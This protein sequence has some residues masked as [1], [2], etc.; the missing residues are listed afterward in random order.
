MK[1]I[2][3]LICILIPVSF[4]MTSCS[5]LD[6]LFSQ[7]QTIT[8][9]YDE[10]F[11]IVKVA[12]NVTTILYDGVPAGKELLLVERNAGTTNISRK[13]SREAD[14]SEIPLPSSRGAVHFHPQ[15][16]D[17]K[18]LKSLQ[19]SAESSRAAGISASA[20]TTPV[21][22]VDWQT[23]DEKSLYFL[24][25]Y[26]EKTEQKTFILKNKNNACNVWAEE[27][28][29]DGGEYITEANV[30]ECAE[31]LQKITPLM[32]GVFG[33]TSD[34]IWLLEKSSEN[35][36]ALT[37]YDDTGAKLNVVLIPFGTP[38][39]SNTQVL[40]YFRNADLIYTEL[41]ESNYNYTEENKT[42][43]QTAKTSNK[44]NYLYINAEVLNSEELDYRSTLVHEFQH[45]I[46]FNNKVIKLSDGTDQTT[47]WNE[48]LSL[49]S[50][51]MF[52]K[53]ITEQDT[54]E[55]LL[56]ERLE[57]FMLNYYTLGITQWDN[58]DALSYSNAYAFGAWLAR[59]YGGAKLINE[60]ST[61]GFVN[62]EAVV[63]AVNKVNRANFTF[64][65]LF[66][67]F[68]LA[69]TGNEKYTMNQNAA[70]DFTINDYNF[71]M[72][73]IDLQDE[74]F[75]KNVWT[76]EVKERHSKN[77]PENFDYKGILIFRNGL[78][79]GTLRAQNGISIMNLGTISSYTNGSEGL[80]FN[81]R[82]GSSEYY[83]LVAR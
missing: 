17:F 26:T 7:G 83:Y 64:D 67:Q 73:K 48:M 68:L 61:N 32:K 50:E 82:F 56:Q 43:I 5:L 80:N 2:K 10:D 1:T 39:N 45:L 33:E 8:W 78:H 12:P 22:Q 20:R 37:D 53:L 70:G 55:P 65:D 75:N 57:G 66:E 36:P 3:K 41:D 77:L 81:S 60:I 28:A 21:E 9:H 34:K 40:G 51:D 19:K 69:I 18:K 44:G 23:G 15:E 14:F 25:P 42:I 71:P 58:N 62:E 13:A 16:I 6:E 49:L 74:E 76:R 31:V 35:F 63:Q 46:N 47:Y 59:Q 79:A 54:L 29:S 24:N 38:A 4:L 30:E 52:S 11:P 72:P 27:N